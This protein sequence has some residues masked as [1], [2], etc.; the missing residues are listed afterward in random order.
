M[1]PSGLRF[2][3]THGG[4]SAAYHPTKVI[5]TIGRGRT[6][7][8]GDK[9]N[10]RRKT[11]PPSDPTR[12]AGKSKARD[13]SDQGGSPPIEG[14]DG[15]SLDA[16]TRCPDRRLCRRYCSQHLRRGGALV[17]CIGSRRQ[18]TRDCCAGNSGPEATLGSRAARPPDLDCRRSSGRNFRR[19]H[20]T[21]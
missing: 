8:V 16:G 17:G 13:R 19:T 6:S 2:R 4:S 3:P 14:A 9:A 5:A 21:R 1:R 12:A 10:E 7:A 15:R 11:H 18:W 20:L